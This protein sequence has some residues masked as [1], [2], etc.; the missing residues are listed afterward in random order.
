MRTFNNIIIS[1]IISF[2]LILIAVFSIQNITPISLSFLF[3][4]SIE[5]PVG[6]MLSFMVGLGIFLGGILPLLL[7]QKTLK[8][9]SSKTRSKFNKSRKIEEEN[10][11]LF[12]WE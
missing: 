6:V 8:Q 3:F 9:K 7:P 12:D 10:D 1:L 2:W 4:K 5:I 11:P